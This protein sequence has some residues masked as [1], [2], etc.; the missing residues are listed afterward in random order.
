MLKHSRLKRLREKRNLSLDQV[1]QACGCYR[2]AVWRWERQSSEPAPR[3]RKV[4]AQCLGLSLARLGSVVY[5]DSV[6][7]L[8]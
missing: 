3:Y 1:A 2:S 5:R 8:K 7:G 6:L 4:Y